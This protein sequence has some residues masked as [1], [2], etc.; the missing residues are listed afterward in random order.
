ML[1]ILAGMPRY[2]SKR[3]GH[4]HAGRYLGVAT[5]YAVQLRR[6]ADSK[7]SRPKYGYGVVTKKG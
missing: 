2:L 6:N 4:R 1:I 3:R 5:C 7:S